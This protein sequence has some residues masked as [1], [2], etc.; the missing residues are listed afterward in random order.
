[1]KVRALKRDPKTPKCFDFISPITEFE[2][3]AIRDLAAGTATEHQ[4][5]LALKCIMNTISGAYDQSFVPGH[6]DQT[7]FREGRAFVGKQLDR[8]IR[9]DIDKLLGAA[10]NDPTK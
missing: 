10:P 6:S 3:F 5:K 2:I 7:D 1:M 8:L 4:Q 9:A